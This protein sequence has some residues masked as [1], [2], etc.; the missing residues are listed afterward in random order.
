MCS[1][2][3][4]CCC[5]INYSFFVFGVICVMLSACFKYDSS[6]THFVEIGTSNTCFYTFG[7]S[8]ILLILLSL[9]KICKRKN[10]YSRLR[11]M[12][13]EEYNQVIQ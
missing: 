7:I 5:N 13:E 4:S 6:N 9:V 3:A 1:C 10:R 11:T 12:S 8:G 2:L